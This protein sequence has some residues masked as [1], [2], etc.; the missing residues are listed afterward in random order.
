[1]SRRN[2]AKAER[3]AQLRAKQRRFERRQEEL[4]DWVR[5]LEVERDKLAMQ[6]ECLSPT[7]RVHPDL[8]EQ[9]HQN[10]LFAAFEKAIV[11]LYA[12]PR[13]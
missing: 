11:P 3:L 5:E 12:R 2:N 6:I 13:R 1:M 9:L 7:P 10:V 8:M 4:E